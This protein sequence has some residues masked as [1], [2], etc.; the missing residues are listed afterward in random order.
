[1]NAPP[2]TRGK[3]GYV[4]STFP[5]LTETF[6][7]REIEA[8]KCRGFDIVVFAVRRPSLMPSGPTLSSAETLRSCAYARPDRLSRHSS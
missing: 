3:I 2:G 5:A 1:M 7:A 6:I 8:L 4:V